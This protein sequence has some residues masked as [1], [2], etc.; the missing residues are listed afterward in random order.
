VPIDDRRGARRADERAFG[1]HACRD[2]VVRE[3]TLERLAL[4]EA[5]GLGTLGR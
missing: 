1:G 5:Q 4:V 3:R 2:E